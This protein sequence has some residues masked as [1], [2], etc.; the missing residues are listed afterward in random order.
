ML[1]KDLALLNCEGTRL[2]GW[3]WVVDIDFEDGDSTAGDKLGNWPTYLAKSK[4]RCY[5]YDAFIPG[6]RGQDKIS[7]GSGEVP[8]GGGLGIEKILDG[9]LVP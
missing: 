1:Q 6:T 8:K 3:L 9:D 5:C 4:P 2:S 7:P